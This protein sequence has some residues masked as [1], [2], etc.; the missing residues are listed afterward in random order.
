MYGQEF[1]DIREIHEFSRT[2]LA[3]ATGIDEKDIE[4]LEE[5]NSLLNPQLEKKL[6]GVMALYLLKKLWSRQL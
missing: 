1:K 6:M 5:R 2:F 4:F 3:Q